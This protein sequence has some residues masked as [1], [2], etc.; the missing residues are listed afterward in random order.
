[1]ARVLLIEDE[2]LVRVSLRRV[3]EGQGH[4]VFEAADGEEGVAEFRSMAKVF[5]ASDVVITDILMPVKDGHDTITEIKEITPNAKIIAI[6]GGG[7][8]NPKVFL[9]ISSALGADRVLSKPFSTE[10]FLDAVNHC[11]A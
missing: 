4:E 8:V 9:D 10:E 5:K 11:L 3:L 1:M 2:E 7:N 6:S